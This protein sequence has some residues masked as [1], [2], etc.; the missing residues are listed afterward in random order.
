MPKIVTDEAVFRATVQTVIERGYT[1]ATTKQIAEAADVSEVTLFRKY[2][3]KAEL[4]RQAIATLTDA[5]DFTTAAEYTGDVTA[6]L[7][8]VVQSYQAVAEENGQ[9]MYVLF[10]EI[11]RHPELAGLVGRPLGMM[12]TVGRLMA[13]YQAEGILRQEHPLHAVA[14]LLGPL[15]VMN[16]MREVRPDMAPPPLDLAAHVAGFVNGRLVHA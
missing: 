6:D 11:P 2:G 9:F 3:S 14:A 15:M 4:V 7:L 16:M 8:R 12:N 13:R 5:V 1:G 10:T